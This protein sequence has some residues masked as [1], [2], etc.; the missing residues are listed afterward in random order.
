MKEGLGT[1]MKS[2]PKTVVTVDLDYW[3]NHFEKFSTKNLKFLR[4]LRKAANSSYLIWSH[5]YI[6]ELIPKGTE[7]IINID[8]HNDIISER[9]T[10]KKDLN[11]GTWA[12][13]VPKSV[14]SSKEL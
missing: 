4:E 14:H 13:F 6:L 2:N 11:E 3:T 9:K 10:K 1:R 5:H 12:N 8:Y 7:R